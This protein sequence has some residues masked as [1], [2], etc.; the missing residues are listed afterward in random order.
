MARRM[1]GIALGA[2]VAA[3]AAFAQDPGALPAGT[4]RLDPAHTTVTFSVDHLGLSMFRAGFDRVTGVLALDPADPAGATLSVEIEAAS[5]DL[6]DPGNGFYDTMM[7][8]TFLAAGAHPVITFESDAVTLTG[9]TG[10]DVAGAL[11]IRGET[12]PV[13]LRTE[14]G[15]GYAPGIL[16]PNGRIG[17]SAET[18]ILRSE[19]GM[20]F[21]IPAPG[22][23]L[24]VGDSVTIRIEAEFVGPD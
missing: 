17:F 23:V 9:E 8:E 20:T 3:Q 19:F 5:L 10:A 11:T 24:G 12:R 14:V 22:T 13:V 2:L 4:Y 15:A 7:S 21:G 16:E 1:I 6:P 18:E